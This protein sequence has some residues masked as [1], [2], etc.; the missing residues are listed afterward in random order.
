M[1][2]HPRLYF[3][4]VMPDIKS[5]VALSIIP[6]RQNLGPA[7]AREHPR[8]V[9]YLMGILAALSRRE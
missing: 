6:S 5:F 2:L 7:P 3:T 4:E 9:R 8:M 1:S